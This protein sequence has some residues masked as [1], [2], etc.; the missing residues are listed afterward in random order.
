VSE[1]QL[2]AGE[3]EPGN[4]FE[5]AKVS[6]MQ[7]IA[8]DIAHRLHMRHRLGGT[9]YILAQQPHDLLALIQKHWHKMMRQALAKRAATDD[10]NTEKLVELSRQITYMQN[11]QFSENPWE[12]PDARV[13]ILTL[14]AVIDF[15]PN[16]CAIYLTT[17]VNNA[18]L[19]KITSRMDTTRLIVQYGSV[20]QHP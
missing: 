2:Q 8:R 10:S 13:F 20:D 4:Y 17:P 14:E 16:C 9:E 1:T 11:L 7:N 12:T 19:G 6:G 3:R 15:P 5:Q 18:L